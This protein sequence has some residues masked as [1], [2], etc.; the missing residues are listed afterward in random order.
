MVNTASLVPGSPPTASCRNR[1][2]S[3]QLPRVKKSRIRERRSR[4]ARLAAVARESERGLVE[5][6]RRLLAL[7]PERR[8]NFQRKRVSVGRSAL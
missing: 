7:P 2:G 5:M 4:R 8:T 6:I 1:P 3:A